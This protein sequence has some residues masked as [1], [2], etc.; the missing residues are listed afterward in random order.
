MQQFG[1]IINRP[2]HFLSVS[3]YISYNL[4]ERNI[5][6]KSIYLAIFVEPCAV[7]CTVIYPTQKRDS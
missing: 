3:K 2:N 5:P 7:S 1:F 6:I 4:I